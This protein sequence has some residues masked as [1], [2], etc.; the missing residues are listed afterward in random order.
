MPAPPARLRIGVVLYPG[1]TLLDFIGPVQV[2]A[3]TP[4][5]EVVLLAETAAPVVS[6]EGPAIVPG[7]TFAAA[8]TSTRSWCPAAGRGWWPR[9]GT[10]RC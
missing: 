4:G 10:S 7:G 9:S 6:N 8:T 3:L 1:A 5:A 2:F